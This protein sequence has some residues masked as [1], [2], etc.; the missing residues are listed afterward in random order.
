MVGSQEL[1]AEKN[2]PSAILKHAHATIHLNL[3]GDAVDRSVQGYAE[4]LVPHEGG[5]D[6]SLWTHVLSIVTLRVDLDSPSLGFK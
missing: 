4:R 6:V 2:N 5:T 3:D 1:G